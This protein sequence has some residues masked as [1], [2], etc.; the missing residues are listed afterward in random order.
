MNYNLSA[1]SRI[2]TVVH[3]Q[4]L[5]FPVN[6]T[7]LK[8]L[9]F[10]TIDSCLDEDPSLENA[11]R[12]NNC[13]AQGC[14]SFK[15][16]PWVQWLYDAGTQ[17][18]LPLALIWDKSEGHPSFRTDQIRLGPVCNCIMSQLLLPYFNRCRCIEPAILCLR[19]YYS[20]AK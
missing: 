19:V 12:C 11:F 20:K 14:I 18:A 17:I 3:H 1:T 7:I 13:I 16:V 4:Q 15:V 10:F 6:P 9:G 8:P 5:F 2:Y